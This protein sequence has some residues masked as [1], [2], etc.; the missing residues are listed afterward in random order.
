MERDQAH[1]DFSSRD[2]EEEANNKVAEAGIELQS[3]RTEK[4]AIRKRIVIINEDMRHLAMAKH[5][6][7][8]ITDQTDEKTQSAFNAKRVGKAMSK[9]S[10]QI[11]SLLAM[12]EPR[13][14]QGRTVYEVHGPRGVAAQGLLMVVGS[15]DLNGESALT[16]MESGAREAVTESRANP[17]NPPPYVRYDPSPHSTV[18]ED[19]ETLASMEDDL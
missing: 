8:C 11:A 18:E 10:R 5:V 6:K 4:D 1:K 16:R 13:I 19:I 2:S 17:P 3:I 14:L 12:D 15:V 9:F 7:L